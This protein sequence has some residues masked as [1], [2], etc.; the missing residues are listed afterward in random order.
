MA[1]TDLFEQRASECRRLA[2][3]ARK[4]SDRAFWLELVERWKALESQS[5]RRYRLR[6]G[7][8]AGDLQGHSPGRGGE[9]AG[10][11]PAPTERRSQPISR[12]RSHQ[13]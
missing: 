10:A 5:A 11:S 9:A 1:S 12:S 3:A 8:V 13:A 4:G 6:Q 2:A 7:P